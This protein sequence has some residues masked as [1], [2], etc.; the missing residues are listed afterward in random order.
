MVLDRMLDFAAG[1]D[2]VTRKRWA[3][4]GRR[5]MAVVVLGNAVGL[6]AIVAAA[7]HVQRA[8]EAARTSSVFFAAN[9]T[10]EACDLFSSVQREAQLSLSISAVQS[11]C[12]VDVLLLMR[13]QIVVTTVV[14]FVAFV[15]LRAVHHVRRRPPVA[16]RREDMSWS[17]ECL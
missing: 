2:E 3:A 9:R 17:D 12:E 5:V 15:V 11:F 6:A 8:A 7:V 16:K 4:G 10:Q 14:V 13:W 1:Q